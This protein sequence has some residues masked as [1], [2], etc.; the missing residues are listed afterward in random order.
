M[1]LITRPESGC[2]L[3]AAA[4]NPGALAMLAQ[5][6]SCIAMQLQAPGPSD[7]ELR[8]LLCLGARTPDHGKLS[9]WRFIL[10]RSPAKG[11]FAD[12]LTALAT[13]DQEYGREVSA[14]DFAAI[15]KL[16]MPPLSVV[17][18]SRSSECRIPVWEQELS[19][20]AVCMNL[21]TAA[22]AM[23]YGANWVTGWYAYD[24]RVNALLGLREGER[25]AGYILLGSNSAPL[26]ER[27]RCNIDELVSDWTP[28]Q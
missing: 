19:A 17:V 14:K 22:C 25:I 16:R 27:P 7:D 15:D 11:H 2:E 10:L 18:I 24:E 6:R 5:R 9:P 21:L 26:K 13:N 8:D 1:S 4:A 12:Q 28:A 20:G 23:G 3:P